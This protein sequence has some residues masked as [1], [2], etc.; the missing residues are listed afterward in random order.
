[1]GKSSET[2]RQELTALDAE[3]AQLREAEPLSDEGLGQL[4]K[5]QARRDILNQR[6]CVQIQKEETAAKAD[7]EHRRGREHRAALAALEKRKAN[8]EARWAALADRF[9]AI[10]AELPGLWQ[11]YHALGGEAVQLAHDAQSMGAELSPIDTGL[12]S[13]ISRKIQERGSL[14]LFEPWR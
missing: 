13:A 12:M 7:E 6:A 8:I 5:L 9:Q 14:L 4:V 11:E 2:L 1:M 10:L 3:L